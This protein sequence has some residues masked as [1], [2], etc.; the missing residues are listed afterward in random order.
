VS[1]VGHRDR[2]DCMLDLRT[3]QRYGR[4]IRQRRFERRLRCHR[5]LR[6]HSKANGG[7]TL[8]VRCRMG[9]TNASLSAAEKDELVSLG[10]EAM[11]RGRCRFEVR[12]QE[13]FPRRVVLIGN[14]DA[15]FEFPQASVGFQCDRASWPYKNIQWK[16]NLTKQKWVRAI[17][18]RPG[19][20]AS[21]HHVHSSR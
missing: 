13:A 1:F 11:S 6:H 10:S 21:L 9:Q 16:R 7:G 19:N 4:L 5:G 14:P 18:V 2:T 12:F 8:P 15:V 17:E 3:S 20:R